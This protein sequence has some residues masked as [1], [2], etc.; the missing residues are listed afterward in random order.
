MKRKWTYELRK[1]LYSL[2]VYYH[3]PYELWEKTGVPGYSRNL[4]GAS[5]EQTLT[6]IADT[7]TAISGDEFEPTAVQQQVKWATSQ[8]AQ[9]KHTGY[10][11]TQIQNLVAAIDCGFMRNKHLEFF[12][13]EIDLRAL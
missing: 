7:L 3:G 12:D 5:Y 9:V 2:L 13:G 4:Q 1:Y 11:Y 8:Q 10:R 6:L